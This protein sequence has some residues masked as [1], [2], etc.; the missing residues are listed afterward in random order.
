[1]HLLGS[2]TRTRTIGA[3][4]FRCPREQA[5]RRY[6]A[7]V[8]QRWLALG[9]HPLVRVEETGRF[10]EC[11]SCSS[12]FDPGVLA[13]SSLAPVEDV[14][15]RALRRTAGVL[16]AG[17]SLLTDDDR[18]EAVIVLQRYAN[19]PYGPLDLS[20][21]L[22][23]TDPNHI[24]A[25]LKALAVSLNDQGRSAILDAGMQLANPRGTPDPGRIKALEHVGSLLAIPDDMVVSSLSRRNDALLAG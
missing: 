8:V 3:G 13:H 1:M 6:R 19:V 9:R 4:T 20:S 24:D 25:E 5:I 10:V 15:T 17:S 12:T 18:R 23:Q 21:D 7:N 14:L 16:L 11:Q 2:C 22:A